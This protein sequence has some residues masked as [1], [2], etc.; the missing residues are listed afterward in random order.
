VYRADKS[1]RSWGVS[2]FVM[3]IASKTSSLDSLSM[4]NVLLASCRNYNQHD[5]KSIY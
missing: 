3:N 5:L 1:K 4:A 2:T